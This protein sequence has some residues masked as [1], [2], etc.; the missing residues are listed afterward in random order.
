MIGEII[1]F[2]RYYFISALIAI[3]AFCLMLF[4]KWLFRRKNGK[5]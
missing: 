4:F 1:N 3:V 5:Q 2:V